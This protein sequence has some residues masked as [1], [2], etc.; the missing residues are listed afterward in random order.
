MKTK[1]RSNS[2]RGA[3]RV[4]ATA[5][6]KKV[7]AQKVARLRSISTALLLWCSL[8]GFAYVASGYVEKF[9]VLDVERVA[10]SG[11]MQ[12][13]DRATVVKQVEPLLTDGFFF[14]NLDEVK[15]RLEKIA[16][17]YQV[18]VDRVWPL[19]LQIKVL[20]Q[21]PIALWNDIAYVNADGVLFALDDL[22]PMAQSLPRLH[23]EA[24][25]EALMVRNF[26]EFRQMLGAMESSIAELNYRSGEGYSVVLDN[27]LPLYFGESQLTQKVQ[28][29]LSVYQ[30][31]F[32]GR[33]DDLHYIDLRY[34]NGLAVRWRDQEQIAVEEL[35]I[36]SEEG[37]ING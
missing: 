35:M 14:I 17:V 1:Q 24:G 4:S 37:L 31:V 27:G 8:L 22:K 28:R 2:R 3:S 9:L 7:D 32:K 18:D 36:E 19:G 10:V 20:E 13:V 33:M 25:S 16:W 26:M 15:V 34:S 30:R 5:S 21:T 6:R 11:E 12:F 23:G 29:F